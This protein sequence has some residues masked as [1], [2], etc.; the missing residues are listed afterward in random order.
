ME[1][2]EI[3]KK[4]NSDYA[5]LKKFMCNKDLMEK[6]NQQTSYLSAGITKQKFWH[7]LN[8]IN[9][10]KVC[11]CSN[12]VKWNI[13]NNS[14]RT[15]CSSK[16]AHNNDATKEKTENT[17]MI[18]FGKK[19]YLS[20]DIAKINYATSMLEKF[21]VDNPFKSKTLQDKIHADILS[22]YG[23]T[24][25]SKLDSIKCKITE[26]HRNKY[27]RDRQCQLHIPDE[28][29]KLKNDRNYLANLYDSGKSIYDIAEILNVGHSQL[30]IKFQDLGIELKESSG[31]L[32]I[33]KFIGEIYN[34]P[35]LFNDRKILDGKEID[36]YLPEF[37]IG[38]EYDGLYWHCEASRGKM[39]YHAEKDKFAKSVGIKLFHITDVE[40]HTKKDICKSR[41][42]S[43]L[44][45]NTRIFARKTRL[46][47]LDGKTARIFFNANHIQGFAS[48]TLYI[49]LEMDDKIIA[50]MSVGKSRFNAC[51][52]EL[53]RYCSIL[54]T[55]VIGGASKLFKY[56]CSV[57]DINEIVSF[58]DLRWGTGNLYSV[59][60]FAHQRDNA[61]SY[62]YTHNYSTLENR[63]N[64]Q[65]HKLSKILPIYD[66]TLSEWENM[67][68]NGYDR[69]WNSGNAVYVWKR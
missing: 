47:V 52:F 28:I 53:I 65:K 5:S 9:E 17:C 25:M 12:P 61:Q 7:I 51:Q 31:Q 56:A 67:K 32:E 39:D 64:Y 66:Q 35:I 43:F 30:C 62:S 3:I 1:F 44:K 54:N 34:G 14:Y 6:L 23:V 26:T 55:N 2:L 69:Y 63:N 45:L 68:N 16:C 37:K 36:I 42:S 57:L 38:I 33:Y 46:K 20:T 50:C 24:S 21:G 22:E 13:K 48:A 27:G 15:F 29:C 60:G 4:A 11:E 18:R 41:L 49:G 59:L 19:S 10:N 40:W 8:D 58:C